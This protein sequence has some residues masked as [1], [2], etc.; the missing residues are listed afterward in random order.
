MA[1][2]RMGLMAVPDVLVLV[3]GARLYIGD[4]CLLI[5]S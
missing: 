5:L 4:C 3:N 1:F 2:K